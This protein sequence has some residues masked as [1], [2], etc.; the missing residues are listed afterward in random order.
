MRQKSFSVSEGPDWPLV[1]QVESTIELDVASYLGQA[2]DSALSPI[3]AFYEYIRP[4]IT[5]GKPALF[6]ES[7]TYGRLLLL[8]LV[9]ATESYIRS[10][11]AG[12]VMRCPICRRY[13]SSQHV[14]LSAVAYYRKDR[15]PYGL[16]ENVS[17]SGRLAIKKQTRNLTAIEIRDGSS[18]DAALVQFD[19]LCELRHAAVHAGGELGAG[20]VVSVGIDPEAVDGQRSV[21]V[22]FEQFQEA[23]AVCQNVVRAYNAF[24]FV[25]VLQRWLGEARFKGEWMVDKPA[26]VPVC[27]LFLSSKDLGK[28][29]S[30]QLYRKLLGRIVARNAKDV[31]SVGGAVE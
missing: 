18:V 14:P 7:N 9:G 28:Q 19:K 5:L 29:T 11:L 4:M 6:D 24:L 12:L 23:V 13:G 10:M 8:G 31:L 17:L 16:L 21:M 26:F 1:C 27:N 30:Y 20:N 3:D 15:L 25:Q 2:G 22:G